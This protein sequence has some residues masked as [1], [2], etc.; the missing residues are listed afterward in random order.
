[1]KRTISRREFLQQTAL[2]TGLAV[3]VTMTPFG[4]RILSAEEAAAGEFSPSVWFTIMPDES[5]TVY[6][7]KSEMGQGVATSLP[8]LIADELDAKWENISVVFA[9]AADVF[10]DPV[11]GTQAT[12]G[13]TSIRHLYEPLRKAGAAA[14]QMLVDAAA[15]KW[16][17]PP[18]DCTVSEGIV[19]HK[20]TLKACSFGQLVPLAARRKPPV[21]PRLK[22][23]AEHRLIGTAVPRID[24]H[25]KANGSCIFGMDVTVPGMLVAAV[26]HPPRFGATVAS[27]DKAAALK[28]QG[29][30]QV[31]EIPGGVAVCADGIVAA[32]S[33]VD[34]LKATWKG[35]DATLSNDSLTSRF[36]AALTDTGLVAKDL[37]DAAGVLAAAKK[38]LTADYTLPFL[39]HATMEPMNCTAHVTADRCKVWVP[40]QNQTGVQHLATQISGLPPERVQVTTTYLGGGFGR[41][42]ELDVV[43][44]ALRISKAV[45][46]PVKVIWNREDDLR[47]DF[48]R[49]MNVSR[50]EA[51]LDGAGKLSA[52]QHTIVCPSIFA[53]VF[54]DT[55]RGGIDQAAVEGLANLDYRVPNLRVTYVRADTP[56]PVGFWRSVGSSHN[57][58][59][60]ESMMDE[61]ALAAGADPVEFRLAALEHEPHAY[62]V[63]KTAAMKAGWGRKLPEGHGRGFAFHRSFDTS[64]AQVA[65]VSVDRAR[66]VITVHRVVCA[67]D[68]GPVVNP[69]TV[70]AQ[71]EGAIC[72]GLSAAL[73]ER[74]AIVAGG[75]GNENFHNY[76][77]LRMAEA[78]SIEVI[79]V[80]GQEKPGGI[81]EP[82][83][84]PI[85]PAVANAVCAVTGVRLRE[86]PL[87]L[88][89]S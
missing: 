57:A 48:Y 44:E 68:C 26:A 75:V 39:A 85:A 27:F 80:K 46:K 88:K 17:V 89:R 24:A 21:D 52:W 83:V 81:G 20:R 62:A 11:W 76:P 36:T 50:V 73:G 22:A 60:V 23:P 37:G 84:P 70:R 25:A 77:I 74:V 41:R 33:G 28:V 82:G 32:Q 8:M 34:A 12:G 55:M 18:S 67:V 64:V 7:A 54:P 56:V 49:P 31:V 61:L 86:L 2:G 6:V 35:G 42:F 58:F 66:G 59:V 16:G 63:V 38:R 53:R 72:F 4:C 47:H 45:G 65:E 29:V 1:M 71:M 10:R 79:L 13:S 5:V 78:P 9:P 30:R 40:T 69:D 51:A 15:E 43:E 19:R 14:R 87:S 3:A